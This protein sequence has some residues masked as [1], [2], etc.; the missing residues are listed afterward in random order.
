MILG[1][2]RMSRPPELLD[3]SWLQPDWT[4]FL[5]SGAAVAHYGGWPTLKRHMVSL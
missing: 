3:A 4:K 1:T 5:G 2:V